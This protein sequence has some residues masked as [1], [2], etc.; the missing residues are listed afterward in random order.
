MSYGHVRRP[1]IGASVQ[2]GGPQSVGLLVVRIIPDSPAAKAGIQTGDFI[3][4]INGIRVHQL[5]DMI[6][7]IQHAGVG[8]VVRVGLLRGSLPLVVHLRLGELP[9]TQWEKT[10]G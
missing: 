3:V 8:G 10:T 2:S 6:P 9:V 7:V 1:W 4:S 5:Q